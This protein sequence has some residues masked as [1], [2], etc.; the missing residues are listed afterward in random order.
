M[1]ARDCWSAQQVAPRSLCPTILL[2]LPSSLESIVLFCTGRARADST[3]NALERGAGGVCKNTEGPSSRP[4]AWRAEAGGCAG[5]WATSK[6]KRR[7]EEVGR[8][9]AGRAGWQSCGRRSEHGRRSRGHGQRGR[10]PVATGCI[11]GAAHA[12]ARVGHVSH[13]RAAGSDHGCRRLEE[14]LWQRLDGRCD[15]VGLGLLRKHALGLVAVA[16][17]LA[18]LLVGVLD[19]DLLAHHVLAVHAGNGGVRRVEVAVGDE[20]VAL[21]HVVLVACNLGRLCQLAELAKRVVERLLVDHGVE[22]ADE[23]LGANLDVL[24]LVG[25]RLVHA[26]TAAVQRDVVHDLG[27]VVGLGLGVELDEAEALVLAVDAVDG[28]V[29]VAHAARVEHQL[30]EEPRR[31]ALMEVADVD[32]GFLV[33]LPVAREHVLCWWAGRVAAYQWRALGADMAGDDGRWGRSR[34]VECLNALR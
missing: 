4:K 13:G 7:R 20:A 29:D 32:G 3:W 33:L 26:H 11:R 31:D 10:S 14:M 5:G 16:L 15:A 24:L 18:V 17:A 23:Q 2:T 27:R 21:A 6:A 34:C 9:A 30:V 19:R 22:V 12:H 1:T 25:R 28:H 8:G